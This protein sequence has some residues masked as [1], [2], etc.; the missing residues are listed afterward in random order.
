MKSYLLKVLLMF[1]KLLPDTRL[2]KLKN[3][4]LR[5]LGFNIH[6]NA[7][8]VS[9]IKISG[10][11]DL[12]IGE[13]TFVG[14]DVCFY[15]NGKFFLGNNVDIAPQ[16]KLLTGSHLVDQLPVR[17]AG[18]GFN[19]CIQIGNGAWIGA[20]SIILPGTTIGE[21]SII[22]AGSVVNK[23]I[24]PFSLYAGNPAQFKKKLI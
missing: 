17:A 2:Y 8:L 6:M 24:E 14:H 4:L 21:G 20:G 19:G 7:R 9:S 15:G 23:N 13:D 3:Y 18:T 10:V 16:V 22:A 12:E 5:L 11:C 1:F